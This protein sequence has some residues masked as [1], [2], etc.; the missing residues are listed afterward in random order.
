MG[1]KQVKLFLVEGTPGGLTTAE[2]TNWT[3]HLVTGPRSRLADLL[4]REEAKRTGVYILLGDD[5]EALGGLRCYIG[6]ADVNVA[7]PFHICCGTTSRTRSSF[8]TEIAAGWTTHLSQPLTVTYTTLSAA[9]GCI[10][11]TPAT[12]VRTSACRIT[13]PPPWIAPSSRY[14]GVSHPGRT[15]KRTTFHTRGTL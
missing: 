11:A 15:L 9:A 13:A 12:A 2:I 5:P 3:G 7:V 6:E 10:A 1:G 14:S 8:T 4:V